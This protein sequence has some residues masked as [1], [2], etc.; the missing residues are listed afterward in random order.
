MGN[1]CC[2]FEAP[3]EEIN[4]EC[5]YNTDPIDNYFSSNDEIESI[6]RLYD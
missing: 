4:Y 2:C 5:V 1:I 6:Y 3:K